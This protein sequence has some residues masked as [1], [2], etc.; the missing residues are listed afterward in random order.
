MKSHVDRRRG[1]ILLGVLVLLLV[2]F[3]VLAGMQTLIVVQ[4][5]LCTRGLAIEHQNEVLRQRARLALQEGL[6]ASLEARD[7][8]HFPER[9]ARVLTALGRDGGT[10]QLEGLEAGA[11]AVNWLPMLDAV[12]VPLTPAPAS[13]QGLHPG[14]GIREGTLVSP[15]PERTVRVVVT[16]P[17]A[18]ALPGVRTFQLGSVGVPLCATSVCFYE[19][20]TELGLQVEGRPSR[21]QGLADGCEDPAGQQLLAPRTRPYHYRVKASLAHAY[22]SLFSHSGV[23]MLRSAAGHE[24]FALLE[25]GEL[26]RSGL[27]TALAVAGGEAH[28]DLSGASLPRVLLVSASDDSLSLSLGEAVAG[29]QMSP[30]VL[31]VLGS[32]TAPL[33]LVLG[34]CA[35]PVLVLAV[36]VSVEAAAGTRWSGG[37]ILASS[38]RLSNAVTELHLSHFSCHAAQSP[39]TGVVRADMAQ[40]ASLAALYPRV[41]YAFAG[42]GQ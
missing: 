23:G 22:A 20:P 40:P 1:G 7:L 6:Q 8:A 10:V 16:G 4:A 32:G 15:G 30:L 37:L 36:N 28:L 9:V 27:G 33:R 38:S 42:G 35:R 26:R 25:A 13:L 2:F 39:R 18:G 11:L 5:D 41:H 14:L 31:L 24:G 34:D 21:G 29:A 3:G 12:P 19:L 17:G